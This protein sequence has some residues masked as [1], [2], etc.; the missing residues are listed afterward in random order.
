MYRRI[1]IDCSWR[2]AAITHVQIVTPVLSYCTSNAAKIATRIVWLSR[3]GGNDSKT[4]GYPPAAPLPA[5][6]Y[7]PA[8]ANTWQAS[9]VVDVIVLRFWSLADV[10]M[11][12]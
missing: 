10:V 9:P 4:V 2:S 12:I 3:A 7:Q 5:A 1:A 8:P 11:E 6:P